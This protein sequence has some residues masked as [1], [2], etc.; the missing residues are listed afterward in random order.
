MHGLFSYLEANPH[1]GRE[2]PAFH[3]LSHGESFLAMLSSRRFLDPGQ[4]LM[5][6]HSP[7][8]AAV[9]DA[10]LL[11]LDEQGLTPTSWEDLDVVDHYR[12]FLDAPMRYLRHV[13]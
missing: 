1:P 5:A 11:Q 4:V 3:E 13:I 2:D 12:R 10:T 9:P 7:V 8:L 6:T